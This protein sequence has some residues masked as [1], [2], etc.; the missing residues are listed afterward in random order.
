MEEHQMSFRRGAVRAALLLAVVSVGSLVVS[1]AAP[2]LPVPT[3][4]QNDIDGANDQPNQKDLTRF[5]LAIGDGMPFDLHTKWN[6]DDV[7]GFTGSN[8]GE[9]CS[10]FDTDNN[11]G[12]DLAVCVTIE[13]VMVCTGDG[14][15]RCQSNSDCSVAGGTCKNVRVCTGDGV[16]ACTNNSGWS[17]AGGVC[18]KLTEQRDGSPRLFTCGDTKADRCQGAVQ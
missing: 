11:G 7:G 6:W 12:A 2:A 14:V 5:C 13:S 4:C 10:L 1:R 15:T 9:A 18:R 3:E 17:V 16:T 8:T